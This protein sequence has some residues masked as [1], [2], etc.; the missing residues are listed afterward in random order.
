MNQDNLFDSCSNLVTELTKMYEGWE[1]VG[2]LK[3]TPNR[4]VRMYQEFC[5]SP[6]QIKVELDRHFRAFENGFDEMLV[7]GPIIVWALCPHHLLPVE[8][9][10]TIGYIPKGFVL[11]LSKFVRIAEVMGKRPIMQEQYSKELVSELVKRLNPK[12]VAVYIVGRHGCMVSR[13]V[14]QDA[15]VVTSCLWGVFLDEL[16]TRAEFFSTVGRLYNS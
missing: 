2:Q 3:N 9:K 16:T 8:L 6:D 5:W 13:G 15:P 7:T 1:G 11:G 14:K 12:G 4:L 10:V